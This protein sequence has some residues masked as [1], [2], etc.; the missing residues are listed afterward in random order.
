MDNPLKN[1][2]RRKTE[3]SQCPT[4]STADSFRRPLDQAQLVIAQ[5]T[6]NFLQPIEVVHLPEEKNKKTYANKKQIII[7]KD[8]P[9]LASNT[10]NFDEIPLQYNGLPN[11]DFLKNFDDDIGKKPR[12]T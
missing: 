4:F 6:P 3:I 9:V 7:P 10:R 5:R 2:V 12:G 11:S 8:S 1:I